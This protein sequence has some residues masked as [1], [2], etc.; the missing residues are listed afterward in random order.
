MTFTFNIGDEVWFIDQYDNLCHGIVENK[1]YPTTHSETEC[2]RVKERIGRRDV[3][4]KKCF[5]TKELCLKAERKRHD[6]A[7]KAYLDDMHGKD[8]LVVFCLT[9]VVA[10]AEEY[11][12]WTA[13]DAAVA[14]AKE[15]G[16]DLPGN[17]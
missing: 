15:L 8:D 5:P 10:P 6:D 16:I 7:V 17:I 14:K 3:Q 12:D 13:R 11:T 9:H 1:T 2:L 4:A